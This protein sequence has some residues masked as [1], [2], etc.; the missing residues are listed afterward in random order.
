MII[1]LTTFKSF[2]RIDESG[3][4]DLI[5]DIIIP[6][7]QKFVE[8]YIG[9]KLVADSLPADLQIAVMQIALHYYDSRGAVTPVKLE[10]VPLS[11][12]AIL[13]AHR[14]VII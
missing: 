9:K 13:N 12:T 11:L 14:C 8:N 5:A 7:A 2:A 4:D 10:R 1:S 3:D 6:A